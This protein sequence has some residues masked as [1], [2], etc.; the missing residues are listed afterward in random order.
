[1][2]QNNSDPKECC[3]DK[4]I[5]YD[6]LVMSE[7][8]YTPDLD[9]L[10]FDN[11]C[12][13]PKEWE[14]R[15]YSSKD[16]N[17]KEYVKVEADVSDNTIEVTFKISPS[18]SE[19]SDI[20]DLLRPVPA[21]MEKPMDNFGAYL[22]AS[23]VFPVSPFPEYFRNRKKVVATVNITHKTLG[24]MTYL[25]SIYS[26]VHVTL[27][28]CSFRCEGSNCYASLL[29]TVGSDFTSPNYYEENVYSYICETQNC[30]YGT[31]PYTTTYTF[32]KCPS[33]TIEV[34]KTFDLMYSH[35]RANVNCTH[36]VGNAYC[37]TPS[38][39]T[40]VTIS[41]EEVDL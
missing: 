1:M 40:T 31:P 34:N 37:F 23:K 33:K 16:E 13:G 5:E 9:I 11:I 10:S 7:T 19:N 24:G 6:Y 15:Y 3:C 32:K 22:D 8:I 36:S 35:I 21:G 27:E 41:I 18:A 2:T 12:G 30:T 29:R 25:G 4:E 26:R 39:K 38:A 20:C 17:S 14:Y 28:C